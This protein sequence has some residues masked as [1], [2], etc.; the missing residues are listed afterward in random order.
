M[1][2]RSSH[3]P[4]IDSGSY[5]HRD[6]ADNHAPIVNQTTVDYVIPES[7]YNTFPGA[8]YI[9]YAL[10]IYIYIFVYVYHYVG[11]YINIYSCM[12]ISMRIC[13]YVYVF[14]CVYVIYNI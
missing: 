10:Y 1:N 7:L 9:H 11:I 14:M 3:L 8:P 12:Y 2:P 6:T 5:H 13:I 4:G